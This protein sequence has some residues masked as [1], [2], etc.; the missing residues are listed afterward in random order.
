MPAKSNYL[1][2]LQRYCSGGRGRQAQVAEAIG[3]SRQRIN[4]WIAGRV[5]PTADQILSLLAFLARPEMKIVFDLSA[6][7]EY[8]DLLENSRLRQ[9]INTAK[10]TVYHTSVFLDE[11]LRM[12]DSDKPGV[13][14]EFRRLWPFI[15]SICNGG[16]F[17]PLLFGQL[18]QLKSVC[19]E[20]LE[21]SEKHSN[22]PCIPEWQRKK[23]EAKITKMIETSDS[24]QEFIY[25][26]KVYE[27]NAELKQ[28]NRK[29][30]SGLRRKRT[31]LKGETFSEYY[32]SIAEDAGEL[33]I[34][35]PP[36]LPMPL[37]PLD[38]PEIK[39]AAWRRAPANFPHFTTFVRLWIYSL[40]DAEKNQNSRLDTNW[41]ADAEQLCFLVDVDAMV[42]ADLSFMKQA[43]E[44][45][46]QPSQKSFFT[47]EDFIA[48]LSQC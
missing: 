23:V 48:Y 7:H 35:R 39:F 38:K 17:K 6:F 10:V 13:K 32:D 16:W 18:P 28:N 47:P 36:G 46:W 3:V 24:L 45:V 20:E 2:Q 19:D 5:Q 37:P 12:A 40:Y 33:L 14:A 30:R 41:Q 11:T 4:D 43:F 42:S 9:L 26:R 29:L 21:A 44:A 25:A 22:W 8:F 1:A 27:Q 15:R 31:L 34:H